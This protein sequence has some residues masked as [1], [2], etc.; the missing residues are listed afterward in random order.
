MRRHLIFAAILTVGGMVMFEKLKEQ[1]MGTVKAS[2]LK[3]PIHI[4]V[5]RKQRRTQL[6]LMR[7]KAAAPNRRKFEKRGAEGR[8]SKGRARKC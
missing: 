3:A 2:P 5:S 4:G 6:A 8:A 7:A 1:L